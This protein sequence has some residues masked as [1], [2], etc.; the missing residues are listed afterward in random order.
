MPLD[1]EQERTLSKLWN[2]GREIAINDVEHTPDDSNFFILLV[3][4]GY[5]GQAE[6]FAAIMTALYQ[7]DNYE[8]LEQANTDA[9]NIYNFSDIA[10]ETQW[11][12]VPDFARSLIDMEQFNLKGSVKYHD[13]ASVNDLPC[14]SIEM[15][16]AGLAA[17]AG[18]TCAASEIADPDSGT[19]ANSPWLITH[20]L[21]DSDTPGTGGGTDP[22]GIDV[23]CDPSIIIVDPPPGGYPPGDPTLPPGVRP[24]NHDPGLPPTTPGSNT[25]PVKVDLNCDDHIIYSA[26]GTNATRSLPDVITSSNA[27]LDFLIAFGIQSFIP[28]IPVLD[29]ANAGIKTLIDNELV[30]IPNLPAFVEITEVELG[31]NWV[32]MWSAKINFPLPIPGASITVDLKKD[33][34][35]PKLV[36]FRGGAT[37]STDARNLPPD[38]VLAMGQGA[39]RVQ[40][41]NFNYGM[42]VAVADKWQHLTIPEYEK[43]SSIALN[44]LMFPAV[45]FD[46]SLDTANIADTPYMR[47][48]ICGLTYKYAFHG[49]FLTGSEPNNYGSDPNVV[50][51]NFDF[52]AFGTPNASKWAT[53]GGALI[54]GISHIL[55]EITG[56]PNAT[57]NHSIG[58]EPAAYGDFDDPSGTPVITW[59]NANGGHFN[60][61]AAQPGTKYRFWIAVPNTARDEFWHRSHFGNDFILRMVGVRYNGHDYV[62]DLDV[63]GTGRP[64]VQAN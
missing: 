31:Y 64:T 21:A 41:V 28:I 39:S 22:S 8:R 14:P 29:I 7:L 54:A 19:T 15:T 48:A 5:S 11:L 58:V 44:T 60:V 35:P 55:L 57:Y 4:K 42:S 43:L 53:Q 24:P 3:R 40:N 63:N 13:V 46:E 32:S 61:W 50:H 12:R 51:Q 45:G 10:V 62:E 56:S 16:T 18:D 37:T 49:Y 25:P 59:A 36:F 52:I 26:V 38:M 2:N 27:F 1:K 33:R 30:T 17:A 34:L 9:N 47:L 6:H 20:L 23:C